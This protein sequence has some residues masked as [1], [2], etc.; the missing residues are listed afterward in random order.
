MHIFVPVWSQVFISKQEIALNTAC[1]ADVRG[2]GSGCDA[3][4]SLFPGFRGLLFL[5]RKRSFAEG[6]QRNP[7]AFFNSFSPFK[8]TAKELWDSLRET[9]K[10]LS[11]IHGRCESSC[12]TVSTPA[13][14]LLSSPF[15]HVCHYI[16][17][18]I[19]P[20]KKEIHELLR[21]WFKLLIK[22]VIFQ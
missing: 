20:K 21:L 9:L 16:F 4:G 1:H 13:S 18:S 8:R 7:L 14:S 5:K 12:H 11:K 15:G 10:K 2:G 3:V 22:S 17:I 6:F 19:R